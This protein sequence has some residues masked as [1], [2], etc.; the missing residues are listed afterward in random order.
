MNE[1]LNN[2]IITKKHKYFTIKSTKKLTLLFLFINI[3]NRFML[4][5]INVYR[6]LNIIQ[7][8]FYEFWEICEEK[9]T[10]ATFKTSF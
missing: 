5:N 9:P 1:I 8:P 4:I 3:F 10:N 6:N 7:S 2:D